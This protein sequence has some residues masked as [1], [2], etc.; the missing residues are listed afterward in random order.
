MPSSKASRTALPLLLPTWLV[1]GVFF[2][3][4]LV[5]MLG[6][7][8]AERGI[9]GGLRPISDLREYLRSGAFLANY[10]R[11][12]DGIFLKIG[13]RSLWMAAATTVLCIAVSFPIAYYLALLAPRRWKG[14]LL[15]LVVVPFWTSFLIRTYAWMFILR[16]EG[17][18][19]LVLV[20]SGL[21][22]HPL[23]LLYTQTAVMIGLVYGELPFMI[24]PLFASLEKL[25]RSLLEAAADLGA[26]RVQ[27]FR[28]VT[29]PLTL[30]GLAAGV[31]L[32]F[33]P[34]LGQFVVSDLLGGARSMLLGNLIQNQFAVA[35]NQPFGAALAFE[36]TAAVLLLLLGYAALARRRGGEDLL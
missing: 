15:G 4:P 2:L 25:D 33:I 20:G 7:S 28:R 27:T 10:A 35:R 24:L 1:L 17:L 22:R 8:F 19:N 18:L 11:S 6:I 14:L 16:S 5:L 31:V 13:W 30:P 23:E 3:V 21:L 36:L 9:Y 29:L 32:V 12:F 34:S 26:G